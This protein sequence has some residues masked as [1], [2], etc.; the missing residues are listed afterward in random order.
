[1]A[2]RAPSLTRTQLAVIMDA[3]ITAGLDAAESAT[4]PVWRL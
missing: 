2:A 1:M 4:P 3:V